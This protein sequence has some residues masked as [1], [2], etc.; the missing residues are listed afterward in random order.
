MDISQTA[1]FKSTIDVHRCTSWL[2]LVDVGCVTHGC[3]PLTT[4][5]ASFRF[6]GNTVKTTNRC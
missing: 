5:N 3:S 2:M 1:S 4:V 6:L